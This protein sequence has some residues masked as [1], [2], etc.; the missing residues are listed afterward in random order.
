MREQAVAADDDGDAHAERGEDV[1]EL[2]C[3]EAAAD[4]HQML[5][6]ARGS[7]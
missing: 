3:D 4:D 1:R 6:A 5:R 2:R 7:A